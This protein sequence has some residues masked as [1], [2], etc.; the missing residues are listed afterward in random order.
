MA[1]EH[2]LVLITKDKHFKLVDD[3][4]IVML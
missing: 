2:N 1:K 4:E 3:I